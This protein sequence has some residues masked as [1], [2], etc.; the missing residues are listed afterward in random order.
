MPALFY[1]RHYG[2][3]TIRRCV[4]GAVKTS[5]AKHF[6]TGCPPEDAKERK[7]HVFVLLKH[8]PP[9]DADFR[10]HRD[11]DIWRPQPGDDPFDACKGCGL[12]CSATLEDARK[13]QAL[14]PSLRKKLIA[15]GP[16]TPGV[17]RDTKGPIVGLPHMTWWIPTGS[18]PSGQFR[19][20]GAT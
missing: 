9:Q 15:Y 11:R 7:A 6:P 14:V 4:S 20:Q 8:D 13:M 5:W 10:S 3:D 19:M 2:P 16:P 18:T 1:T 17:V 12:S